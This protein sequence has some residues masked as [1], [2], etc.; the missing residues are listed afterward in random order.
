[1]FMVLG[2]RGGRAFSVLSTNRQVPEFRLRR[3][4]SMLFL[5]WPCRQV[6]VDL[7][8]I[9]VKAQFFHMH[10]ADPLQAMSSLQVFEFPPHFAHEVGNTLR[11]CFF[12]AI[13]S[14]LRAPLPAGDSSEEQLN[15][16]MLNVFTNAKGY[17]SMLESN[18]QKYPE[19]KPVAAVLQAY[20]TILASAMGDASVSPTAVSAAKEAISG[21]NSAVQIAE[22]LQSDGIGAAVQAASDTVIVAGE[23]DESANEGFKL[24]LEALFSEG[25]PVVDDSGDTDTKFAFRFSRDACAIDGNRE[26]SAIKVLCHAFATIAGSLQTWSPKRVA[27]EMEA[28]CVVLEQGILCLRACNLSRMRDAYTMWHAAA[29]LWSPDFAATWESGEWP[30]G[31]NADNS[32]APAASQQDESCLDD[33]DD[34]LAPLTANL[35]KFAKFDGTAQ[36]P[37]EKLKQEID[38]C[39]EHRSLRKLLWVE[40]KHMAEVIVLPSAAPEEMIK[41]FV[42]SD[43]GILGQVL[44]IAEVRSQVSGAELQKLV[45][46][47]GST[48]DEDH[49]ADELATFWQAFLI[50]KC[51]N[52]LVTRFVPPVLNAASS[53]FMERM[54]GWSDAVSNMA[55]EN[56]QNEQLSLEHLAGDFIRKEAMSTMVSSWQ[57]LVTQDVLSI[58]EESAPEALGDILQVTDL[59]HVAEGLR[60][61]IASAAGPQMADKTMFIERMVRSGK[62]AAPEALTMM[63]EALVVVE[64]TL[65][66]VAAF[67]DFAMAI[68][69]SEKC[70]QN[71]AMRNSKLMAALVAKVQELGNSVWPAVQ[72]DIAK[73]QSLADLDLEFSRCDALVKHACKGFMPRLVVEVKATRSAQPLGGVLAPAR[74]PSRS[75]VELASM[76]NVEG[77]G[78]PQGSQEGVR[79]WSLGGP[80]A[81]NTV[82]FPYSDDRPPGCRER[83]HGSF[84]ILWGLGRKHKPTPDPRHK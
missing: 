49:D 6:H 78:Y 14:D 76:S 1:M 41:H 37:M 59:A 7:I 75:R 28:T 50:G 74:S 68:G 51:Q 61:L 4:A 23:L 20:A 81:R 54:P 26:C 83:S 71:E 52:A 60:R 35:L 80:C 5:R 70:K 24:C 25:M 3:L 33:V 73:Q 57:A 31:L 48:D 22:G 32:I 13:L 65:V 34:G 43:S 82:A 30:P 8:A 12:G 19:C 42:D 36:G 79:C 77:C 47:G 53:V 9:V 58:C 27:E 29:R 21:D 63:I 66:L 44:P 18:A 40:Y 62:K 67:V 10:S 17:A 84:H 69:S 45:V 39:K 56:W 55:F 72:K 38:K 11:Q 64:T 2:A 46:D 16:N 15:Q